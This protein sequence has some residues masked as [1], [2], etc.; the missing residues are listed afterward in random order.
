MIIDKA[1]KLRI[2]M[3]V[4]LDDITVIVLSAE[5]LEIRYKQHMN[6]ET[7]RY[8][9]NI[10]NHCNNIVKTINENNIVTNNN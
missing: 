9:K 10:K 7:K 4:I 8:F 6:E 2:A 5:M 3:N 1:E